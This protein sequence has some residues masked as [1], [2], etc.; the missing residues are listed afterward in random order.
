MNLYFL[1][2]GRHTER[3]VY[4]KWLQVL[5]PELTQ[6]R[7]ISGVTEKCY[8]LFS[9]EGFPSLLNNHLR[10]SIEEINGTMLFD[11]LIVC[12]DAD[13]S[14]VESRTGEVLDFMAKENLELNPKCKLAI[15]V[16][17]R[18]IETWF[19]GNRKTFKRNPSK[20]PLI[21]Y[22][23]YYDVRSS[24]P[25]L[26]PGYSNFLTISQ[27]HHSYLKENLSERNVS[28]TKKNPGDVGEKHYLSELISRINGTNHL[29]SLNS[30]LSLCN[31]IKVNSN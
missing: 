11:Y 5:L 18:C 16:Q 29:T 2:E 22:V 4:P 27:F 15:V 13:E 19:L 30:F 14:T 9:G 20:Q 31:E 28:Y 23:N 12:L 7:T 10:N 3:K 8:Y 21:S 25:E 26:M 6:V 1:V 24:D 17:N